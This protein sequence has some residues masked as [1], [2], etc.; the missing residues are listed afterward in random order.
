MFV[1]A[2]LK[3]HSDAHPLI[4][5]RFGWCMLSFEQD[6]NGVRAEIE[7]L[8]RDKIAV[9]ADHLI[10]CDG[11]QGNVRKSL[12]IQ[13]VGKSGREVDFMMGQMLSIYFRRRLCRY[14]ANRRALAVS[15]RKRGWSHLH[16][17]AGWG[18]QVSFLG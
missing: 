7:T 10:G 11:G 15:L 6:N 16:R 14:Y 1:E 5:L 2:V 17:R 3:R 18:G 8:N 12:G 9:K 13:Y 4:D